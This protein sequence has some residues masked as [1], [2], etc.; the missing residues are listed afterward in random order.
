LILPLYGRDI[1]PA[2]NTD[3][4]SGFEKGIYL[5][6]AETKSSIFRKKLIITTL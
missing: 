3:D 1:K 2:N 4:L 6:E 5:I